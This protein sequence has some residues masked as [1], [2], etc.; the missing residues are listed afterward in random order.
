MTW[1]AVKD[2]WGFI[3]MVSVLCGN[4]TTLA[5]RSVWCW[6]LTLGSWHQAGQCAYADREVLGS[7][8]T[9]TTMSCCWGGRF[10]SL[11]AMASATVPLRGNPSWSKYWAQSKFALVVTSQRGYHNVTV[12]TRAICI[13]F[14]THNGA[15]EGIITWDDMVAHGLDVGGENR[16]GSRHPL[17]VKHQ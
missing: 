3:T 11:V 6:W 1:K 4:N 10:G 13:G 5:V 16:V 7:L 17:A 12:T 2:V 9:Q 14:Y 15:I 8:M